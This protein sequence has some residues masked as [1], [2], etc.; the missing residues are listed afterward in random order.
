MV[1]VL[2][3]VA[4]VKGGKFC[5]YGEGGGGKA[6]RLG[7]GRKTTLGAMGVVNGDVVVFELVPEI[8]FYE[9][10]DQF[11]E[12]KVIISSFSFHFVLSFIPLNHF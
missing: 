8:Q 4:G 9:T 2:G 10:Y 3:Q 6:V 1:N 5:I 11:L 12:K 7:G